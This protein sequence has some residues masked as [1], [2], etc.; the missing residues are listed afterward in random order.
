MKLIAGVKV[1]DDQKTSRPRLWI[2]SGTRLAPQELNYTQDAFI[3]QESWRELNE[4]ETSLVLATKGEEIE[5]ISSY[6]GIFRPPEDTIALFTRLGV[7]NIKSIQ[8]CQ[9]LTQEWGYELAMLK[10]AEYILP[11]S[12]NDEQI[13]CKGISVNQP[14]LPT[15]T[16][17]PKKEAYIG[18]HLDSWD[19]LPLAKRYLSS[20]RICI[21]LGIESRYLLFIN[22]TLNNIWQLLERQ[23]PELIKNIHPE[24]V[25]AVRL[26]F[27]QLFPNYPV[28]KL[29]ID[30]G[31]AYI[32][33]TENIIHDGCSLSMSNLDIHLT[34]RGYFNVCA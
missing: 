23:K 6:L 22:L 31:E 12:Q 1:I 9:R 30:P 20:N 33:P 16:Y 15:V 19:R 21:N 11:F 24:N 18:L 28:L 29:R 10:L 26:V 3:P 7:R 32:A 17:N 8:D 4:R 13:V 25:D 27:L 14:G 34:I 5:D 2:N